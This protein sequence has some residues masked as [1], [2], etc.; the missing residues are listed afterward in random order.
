MVRP[1]R[2]GTLFSR[3]A[4]LETTSTLSG[5]TTL[6]AYKLSALWPYYQSG[7][8]SYDHRISAYDDRLLSVWPYYLTGTYHKWGQCGDT[9]R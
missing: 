9:D 5:P 8:T 1:L 6:I 2:A 3:I 7:P 4:W